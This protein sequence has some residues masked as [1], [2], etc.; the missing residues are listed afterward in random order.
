MTADFFGLGVT[1]TEGCSVGPLFLRK[2]YRPAMNARKAVFFWLSEPY[3]G[4][5]TPA[6]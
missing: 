6:K 3:A 4:S 1:I 5:F 2:K